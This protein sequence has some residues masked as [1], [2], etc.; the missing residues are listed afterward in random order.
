MAART[1]RDEAKRD[2][3]LQ[4]LRSGST[5]EHAA[6]YIGVDPTT[7]WR[8]MQRDAGFRR[9][10]E[11]AEAT[12]LV[13][14]IATVSDAAFGRPAQ[15]DDAGR[16]IRAEIK[17]NAEYA[18]WILERKDPLNYGRRVT[19]DIRATVEKY[20]AEHGFDADEVIGEIERLYA[21]NAENYRRT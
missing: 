18:M 5:R 6:R 13:R 7:L 15:Y 21:E 10:C 3:V 11:E 8:W 17:S 16:V 20:A 19:F 12:L 1:P 14:A 9:A 4:L 2:L